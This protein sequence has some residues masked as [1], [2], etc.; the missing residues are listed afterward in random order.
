[1][2]SE[3][4]KKTPGVTLGAIKKANPNINLNKISIGQ[5]INMPKEEDFNFR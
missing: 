5:K 2:L 4:A 1:M 3:I